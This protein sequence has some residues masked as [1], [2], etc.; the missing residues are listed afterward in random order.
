MI[1]YTSIEFARSLTDGEWFIVA[2]G[3]GVLTGAIII[4]VL[5]IWCWK[6]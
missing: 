1:E 3:L 4:I 6:S 5:K 2:A